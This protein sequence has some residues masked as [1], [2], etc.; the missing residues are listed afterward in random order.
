MRI[1]EILEGGTVTVTGFGGDADEESISRFRAL[2]FVIGAV[3]FVERRLPF[4]G[5]IVVRVGGSS[6]ALEIYAA[7]FV[8]VSS[9]I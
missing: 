7:R 4:G 8:R 2:G 9:G 5:P 1:S 6:L 3:V